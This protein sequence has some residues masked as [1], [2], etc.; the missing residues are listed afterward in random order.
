MARRNRGESPDAV[1]RKRSS[2]G[3]M[4]SP[5]KVLPT[6]S[7]RWTRLDFPEHALRRCPASAAAVRQN[8]PRSARNPRAFG[9]ELRAAAWI[10]VSNLAPSW[11]LERLELVRHRCLRDAE[12]LAC[13]PGA[14][15]LAQGLEHFELAHG[16]REA[17]HLRHPFDRGIGRIVHDRRDQEGFDDSG[18]AAGGPPDCGRARPASHRAGTAWGSLLRCSGRSEGSE[19]RRRRDRIR[20]SPKERRNTGC[21]RRSGPA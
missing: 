6:S 14:A 11:F 3:R 15:E 9:G 1:S 18:L 2:L 21:G 10:R 8:S 5:Q 7:L 16:E 4:Q 13:T 20:S 17:G 19:P 12:F